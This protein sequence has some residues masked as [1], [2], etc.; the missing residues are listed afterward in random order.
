MATWYARLF[1][2]MHNLFIS[3]IRRIKRRGVTEPINAADRLFLLAS[4]PTSRIHC[5]GWT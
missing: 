4:V 3:R 2:I 1:A 5:V